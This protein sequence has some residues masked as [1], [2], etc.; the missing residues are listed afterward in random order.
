MNTEHGPF[1][2]CLT[3]RPYQNASLCCTS[4]AAI[5]YVDTNTASHAAVKIGGPSPIDKGRALWCNFHILRDDVTRATGGS[6]KV[7]ET[8]STGHA[9]VIHYMQKTT[10]LFYTILL[11]RK[12]YLTLKRGLD[13]RCL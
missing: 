4:C 13:T 9:P 1:K 2:L 11:C 5:G 3:K 12:T 7:V 6:L 8:T 10:P